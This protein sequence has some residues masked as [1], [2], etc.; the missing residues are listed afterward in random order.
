MF[1]IN[2]NSGQGKNLL[3]CTKSMFGDFWNKY[4]D[5]VEKFIK[6]Y[7]TLR[8]SSYFLYFY[9]FNNYSNTVLIKF[10]LFNSQWKFLR[11]N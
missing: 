11:K 1:A 10:Y 7:K 8:Y 5:A 6:D 4:N 3:S 2:V 9:W